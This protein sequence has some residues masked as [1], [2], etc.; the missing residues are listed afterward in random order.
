V[1]LKIIN[2]KFQKIAM[3]L[4]VRF[5]FLRMVKQSD[6]YIDTINKVNIDLEPR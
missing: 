3:L 2:E 5:K 1:N 4:K 6:Y